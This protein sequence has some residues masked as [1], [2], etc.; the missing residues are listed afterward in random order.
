MTF[1]N[2]KLRLPQVG[3]SSVGVSIY[4]GVVKKG[5]RPKV[6]S[7]VSPFCIWQAALCTAGRSPVPPPA[8]PSRAKTE[9]VACCE[10][11]ASDVLWAVHQDEGEARLPCDGEGVWVGCGRGRGQDDRAWE[12]P[13]PW[14]SRG[15]S[16]LGDEGHG[17]AKPYVPRA[18][19]AGGVAA[20]RSKAKRKGPSSDPVTRTPESWLSQ[21]AWHSRHIANPVG[22][23]QLLPPGGSPGTR[24]W[25][26]HA[27]GL[28]ALHRV[29]AWL[30]GSCAGSSSRGFCH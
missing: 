22:K 25:R 15:G 21:Q 2:R 6:L 18:C 28:P 20:E 11:Y 10:V 16:G 1:K 5:K 4:W 29:Q 26:V 19:P 3:T 27:T 24:A 12:G 8:P 9:R 7:K 14:G 17:S 30:P 23:G 13:E